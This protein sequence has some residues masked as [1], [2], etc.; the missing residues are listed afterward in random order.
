MSE[1]KPVFLPERNRFALDDDGKHIGAAHYRDF[2][3]ADGVERVFFHT[4][5]NDEYGGQGLASVLVKY[6]LENTIASGAKIVAVCPYVKA[7]VAKHKEYEP[8]LVAPTPAHLD[9]LPRG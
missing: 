2:D 4:T 3:G 5:V 8:N 1:I 6:A 9:I 7:Y